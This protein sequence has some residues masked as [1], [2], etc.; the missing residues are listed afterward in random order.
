MKLDFFGRSNFIGDV[1]PNILALN[2]PK[3]IGL[4]INGTKVQ[5]IR[6]VCTLI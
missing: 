6:G 5:D 2:E 4:F 1:G 3:A